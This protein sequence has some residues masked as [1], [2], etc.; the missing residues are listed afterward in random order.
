[1]SWWLAESPTSVLHELR[2]PEFARDD[3]AREDLPGEVPALEIL[4]K[5]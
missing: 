4:E 1:L 2:P 3:L 5:T